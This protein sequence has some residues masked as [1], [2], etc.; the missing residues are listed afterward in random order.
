MGHYIASTTS[1]A[2]RR[3]RKAAGGRKSRMPKSWGQLELDRLQ[4]DLAG[5]TVRQQAQ[6]LSCS[7]ATIDRM[8][9]ALSAR[10]VDP[11]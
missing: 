6:A 10:T 9:R 1:D 8:R 11:S 4:G 7:T 2:W 5:L 3:E